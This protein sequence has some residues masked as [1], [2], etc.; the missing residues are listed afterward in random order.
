MSNFLGL[1][2]DVDSTISEK[3]NGNLKWIVTTLA[4]N[5]SPLVGVTP[6]LPRPT[7]RDTSFQVQREIISNVDSLTQKGER[8]RYLSDAALT[9]VENIAK[10]A[11]KVGKTEIY[12]GAK[13]SLGLRT[14]VTA[15]TLSQVQELTQEKSVSFGTILGSLDSISVHKGI[16]VR[17]WDENIN[18]PVRCNFTAG[19]ISHATNLLGKRVIV[20]GMIRSD[21]NGQPLSMLVES[22]DGASMK[23]L[24]PI[25]ELM[26]AVPNL[27][28]G[29]SL[30]TCPETSEGTMEGICGE[31]WGR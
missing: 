29:L 5:P 9:R 22:L 27:T 3:K 4:K 26:G 8:S 7:F 6:F 31:L 2:R 15:Q 1:L 28:G 24:P 30:R 17:V 12:T 10:T 21:R 14:S 13:G 11:H 25:D 16:E 19:Q 18:R 20:S 23:P